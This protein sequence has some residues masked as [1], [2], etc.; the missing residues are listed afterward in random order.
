MWLL[1]LRYMAGV[2]KPL[3]A[4]LLERENGAP[5]WQRDSELVQFLKNKWVAITE[6]GFVITERGRRIVARNSPCR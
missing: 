3:F 5:K 2:D 4:G 1:E 6:G